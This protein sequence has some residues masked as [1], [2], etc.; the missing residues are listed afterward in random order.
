M[1]VVTIPTVQCV[2]CSSTE[3]MVR[4][5]YH[6]CQNTLGLLLLG[7]K[8]HCK[9]VGSECRESMQDICWPWET[10]MG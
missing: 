10:F 3:V 9:G 1:Q 2:Q 8:L 5:G 4:E 7:K 6:T